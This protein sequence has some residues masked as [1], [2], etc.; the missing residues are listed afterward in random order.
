[1]RKCLIASTLVL[2]ATSAA[3]F[4]M[5]NDIRPIHPRHVMPPY[6]GPP[7]RHTAP[8]RVIV[9]GPLDA[10][11]RDCAF[12]ANRSDYTITFKSTGTGFTTECQIG[13]ATPK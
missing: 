6:Q 5:D 2:T 7:P 10:A 13:A 4:G 9:P 8:S 3:A 1:M 12:R 11:H